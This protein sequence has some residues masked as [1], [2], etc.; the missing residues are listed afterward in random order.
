MKKVYIKS[1]VLTE[2]VLTNSSTNGLNIEVDY[3]RILCPTK[4]AYSLD[5]K[6]Q[7]KKSEM[8]YLEREDIDAG[9]V[10]E[11]TTIITIPLGFQ[12]IIQS[13]IAVD[14]YATYREVNA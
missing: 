14:V 13:S 2:T 1:L 4:V 10:Y 9:G 8:I 6:L 11:G 7:G 5:I 12:L 3:I